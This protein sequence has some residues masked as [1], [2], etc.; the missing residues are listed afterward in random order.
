MD[1]ELR[2]ASV[3]TGASVNPLFQQVQES[4]ER[5]AATRYYRDVDPE[6]AVEFDQFEDLFRRF[7]PEVATNLELRENALSL[8]EDLNVRL[9]TRDHLTNKDIRRLRQHLSRFRE[10]RENLDEYIKRF[11]PYSNQDVT[12]KF[13]AV[14]PSGIKERDGFMGFMRGRTVAINPE[15]DRGRLM[16][17]QLKMWLS[18]VTIVYDSYFSA[19]TPYERHEELRYRVDLATVAPD[20]RRFLDDLSIQLADEYGRA[21]KIVE[22]VREIIDYE[23]RHPSSDLAQDK[24]ND[25]FNLLIEGSYSFH[26][27][28]KVSLWDRV[29]FWTGR[30]DAK[31]RNQFVNLRNQATHDASQ[32]FG[33]IVG[34]HE[35]RKG[36]LYDM[37]DEAVRNITGGLKLLDILLEKTPFRLTDRFIP[38]H[39][40]HLAL[41]V[42]DESAI[43]E[44]KRLGVWQELPEVEAVARRKLGYD[45]PSFQ[46]LI[47]NGHGVLEALRPGVTLNTFKHFLNI[48]DL[49]VLRDA[50]LTDEQK[51][52]F[53][54]RA[55]AQVGKGYDFNFNVQTTDKIVCS[56][57]AF[58]VFDTYEWPVEKN[59]GR[60]VISPDHVANLA[61]RE[62]D[63]FAPVLLFHDGRKLPERH[64]RENL[65]RLLNE[66]YDQLQF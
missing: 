60:Y 23:K 40:G 3:A 58:V 57:L 43:P 34:L 21:V 33:N 31:L 45:G 1:S 25:Y 11:E 53:L 9:R 61:R 8:F 39:W 35:A 49:A 6:T 38:G 7:L 30:S 54:L 46:K 17:L 50:S 10:H 14:G 44:L 24:D 42:G 32:L 41:W 63:P 65:S 16:I 52:D 59:V 12:L 26:R 62:D 29:S 2:R 47:E 19:L 18:A 13:P 36:K 37:P 56:E 48:D 4:T 15:D 55:F 28:P 27:L 64:N 5:T 51:K 66:K 22:L 20:A